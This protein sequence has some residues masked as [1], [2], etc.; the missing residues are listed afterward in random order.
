MTVVRAILLTLVLAAV[1][2][3]AGVWGGA[4]YVQTHLRHA[5][6]LHDILH[7][8]LHLTPDQ[9][10]RIEGLERDHAAR[11]QVLEAEMRAAN[12]ELAQAYQEVHGYTPKAQAA[13]DRFHHAMD[14]LQK[15]TL[16]HVIAMR[17]VLTP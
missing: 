5:P 1:A 17:S 4:R 16:L 14:A 11:R 2:G 13:I 3:A 8:R 15:E 6:A 10:R 7:E 12:A 9:Q